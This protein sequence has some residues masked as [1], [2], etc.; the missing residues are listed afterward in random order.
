[1]SDETA[2]FRPELP[3]AFAKLRGMESFSR[4]M[5]DR[6][7]AF[8]ERDH[9]AWDSSRPF[10][11]RIATLPLHALIFSNPDRDP[12]LHGQT[13]APFYPLRDEMRQIAFL[14]NQ[15]ADRPVVC[16][17]HGRNGFLGSLLANEGVSVMSLRDDALLPCQIE[18][19]N[20]A[21]VCQRRSEDIATLKDPIDVAV[22]AWM[23]SAIN[24]TPA[25]IAHQPKLIVFFYTDHVGEEDGKPQTGTP[26]AYHDLPDDYRLIAE[27]SILRMADI[28]HEVWPDL[29]PSIEEER[30][31]RIFAAKPYQEIAVVPPAEPAAKT[32]Y[33]WEA[34]LEM[35]LTSL[36]AKEFLRQQGH[37]L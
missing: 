25:I 30:K 23:P 10:S 19:F 29:T 32:G 24:R 26:A 31:V 34:D 22:S 14:A 13:V 17:V 9:P 6:I 33:A 3:A 4:E 27:W 1:M 16:D 15:V 37:A 21:S 2:G 12:T 11:E 7:I 36:K 35:A 8:Q 18:D 28:L 20:D 5:F